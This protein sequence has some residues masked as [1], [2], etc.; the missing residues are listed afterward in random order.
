MKNSFLIVLIFLWQANS[1][2]QKLNTVSGFVLDKLNN[3]PLSGAS[4]ILKESGEIITTNKQGFFIISVTGEKLTLLISHVGY[5]TEVWQG[6]GMN[7]RQN[8]YLQVNPGLSGEIVVTATKKPERLLRAP[9]SIRVV[10]REETEKFA[11][12]N[13]S[14]LL[15][16]IQG[17]EMVRSGINM[18]TFNARGFN[19]PLSNKFIFMIDGRNSMSAISTGVGLFSLSSVSTEDVEKIEVIVGPH[20]A[21]YG[22]NVHNGLFYVSTKDPRTYPG[23]TVALSAGNHRQFSSRLRYAQ[24]INDR[25]SFKL[26]GEYSTGRDFI[27]YDT[28]YAGGTV[29]GPAK[30]IPERNPDFDFRNVKGEAYVY[31]R[32]KPKWDLVISGGASS[33]DF[34]GVNGNGRNQMK[35]LSNYFVQGRVINE[36]FFGTIVKSWSDIGH[37][38]N[39]GG[40]TRDY[41]NRTHSLLP[42]SDTT[43]G[44]LSPEDAEKYAKR[45]GVSFLDKGQR[46]NIDLQYNHSFPKH[47]LSII[48]GAT[49]QHE[50]PKSYGTSLLDKDVPIKVTQYGFVIHSEKSLPW[51]IKAIIAAR[52]DHHSNFGSFFSPKLAIIKNL[53]EGSL[54]LTWSKAYSTPSI[55]HQYSNSNF[56]SFGNGPGIIYLPNGSNILDAPVKVTALLPEEINTWE[57]GYKS[58]IGKKLF[59]DVNAYYGNSRN[60]IGPLQTVAGRVLQVGDILVTHNPATAGTIIND[61]LRNASFNTYFNYGKV[62]GYGTDLAVRYDFSNKFNA[63]IRYSFFDSDR[64]KDKPRNDANKDGKV[65]LEEKSLNAPHHRLILNTGVQNLSKHNLFATLTGRYTSFYSF[66]AGTQVSAREGSGKRMPGKNFNRGPLGGYLIVDVNA[67]LKIDKTTFININLTNLFNSSQYEYIGSPAIGRLLSVEFKIDLPAALANQ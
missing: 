29:Y 64:K 39:L 11:G 6:T 35:D 3:E 21:L 56:Q 53:K 17:I 60:F 20:A 48:T 8:F 24:V 26:N 49:Y 43:R 10:G 45:K 30:G 59:V 31:Y 58:T 28:V 2:A 40:Y 52:I 54:R 63:G 67:G 7:D 50:L 37:S 62:N 41:Y 1:I 46:L 25:F 34:L 9:A 44:F 36:H 27:F 22:P 16:N 65:S 13:I 42:A 4:I 61:T 32:F 57:T 51:N 5:Q 33:N 18:I 47:G 66:Y 38:F 15:T 14:E 12:S 19:A 23:T 55:L